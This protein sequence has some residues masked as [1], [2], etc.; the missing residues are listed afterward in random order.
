MGDEYTKDLKELFSNLDDIELI[1]RRNSGS[2]TDVAQILIE[3]EI[4]SRGISK[5]RENDLFKEENK[6]QEYIESLANMYPSITERGVAHLLDQFMLLPI[7]F[8]TAVIT[9]LVLR[10]PSSG[11]AIWIITCLLYFIFS[12]SLPNGQ[13]VGKKICKIAVVDY[14]KRLPIGMLKSFIRN[15]VLLLAGVVDLFFIFSKE[16]RR[17]GDRAA[18]TIVIWAKDIGHLPR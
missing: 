6:S 18:G 10:E 16:R 17:L 14:D 9:D 1:E 11:S 4:S 15:I 5:E 8:F 7:G 3:E 13:S 2:L 12:D